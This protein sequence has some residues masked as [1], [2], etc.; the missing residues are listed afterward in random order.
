MS[1]VGGLVRQRRNG[2]WEGRYVGADHRKH[3]VY[4][5]TKREAQEKVRAALVAADNGINPSRG[6]GTVAEYMA[7]WL[8]ATSSHVRARTLDSYSSTNRL[9]ITPAI[10]SI[11]LA[12]L[13]GTDIGRMV[14]ALRARGDLSPTTVR[15]AY[16]VLRIALGEALRTGRVVQN[17]ALSVRPP[18]A[19]Q[20]ERSPLTLVQVGVFLES[21]ESDRLA[22]L[23]KTAIGLGLRQ[24]EL[25]ALRWSDVNLDAGTLTVRHTR[26]ARTGELAEPKTDRSRRT[27]RLGVELAAA[28]REHRRRQVEERLAPVVGGATATSSSRRR[29]AS[30]STRPTSPTAS[31]R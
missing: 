11:A 28:L 10:G 6:R 15:Y 9:Y 31:T 29:R 19:E 5:K 16:T 30:R 21:V 24:G 8:V 12:R 27:L 3:S 7:Q 23:Y 13:Q 4:A 18:R 26:N 25:L 22:V 1:N 14:A 17:V 2:L 20:Q